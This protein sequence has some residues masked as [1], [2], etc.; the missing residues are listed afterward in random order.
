MD[1]SNVRQDL[2]KVLD[3]SLET[4]TTQWIHDKLREVLTTRST[5]KLYLMYSVLGEKVDIGKS[6][7]YSGIDHE[8]QDYLETHGANSLEISRVFLLSSVLN[9]DG[10][11]YEPKVANIIQV[12]DTGELEVFL[13]YLIVL[14]NAVHYKHAAVEALRTNISIIFDAITLNNPYPSIYFN[15]QQWNQMYLKAAFMQR[16]LTQIIGVDERGNKDLTRIISD[17]AHERWAASREIDP[18]FWRPVS[19][20]IEGVLLDDMNRLFNS[21]NERERKAA[22]LCCYQSELEEARNLALAHPEFLQD[23][24]ENTISWSTI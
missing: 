18:V 5:Q 22:T 17:Y 13:K 11:Y 24:K 16:D 8:L 19:N 14:P 7:D 2:W 12:A 1:I 20:F 23:A 15:E 21:G 9:E 6:I 4:V 10:S 3:Q